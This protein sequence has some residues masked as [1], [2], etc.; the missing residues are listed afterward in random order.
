MPGYRKQIQAALLKIFDDNPTLKKIKAGEPVS[1]SDLKALTSLVLTRNPDVDQEILRE[2]FEGTAVS[3]D[4]AIRSI[5]GMD[6]ES[7]NSRFADF[8]ISHPELSANQ[9]SFLNLLK[10]H[11]S[12]Y[13]AIEVEDLYEPALYHVAQRWLG[14]GFPG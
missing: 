6:A 11:V 3:L 8:V 2:F 1:K 13:G 12:R 7:V 5:I 9:V 14:R 4:Y 10:Y